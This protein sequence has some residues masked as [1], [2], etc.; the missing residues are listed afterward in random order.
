LPFRVDVSMLDDL[1]PQWR[2]S[3]A[4]VDLCSPVRDLVITKLP[5]IMSSSCTSGVAAYEDKHTRAQGRIV[6]DS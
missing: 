4:W 6:G 3:V 1:P 5:F 2:D